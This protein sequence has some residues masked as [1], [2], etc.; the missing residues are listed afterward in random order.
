MTCQT[1]GR[2]PISISGLGRS[3]L[4]RV[5]RPPQRIETHLHRRP[6]GADA[7][8]S[9]RSPTRRPR[10]RSPRACRC[11]AR[12]VLDLGCAAGGLATLL[13]ARG[14]VEVVGIERRRRTTRRRRR[15]RCD[16]V[17]RPTPRRSPT[18]RP[19][20]RARPL[21]LP[22]RR[23]RARAPRRPV[24]A[25]CAR[26]A[27]LLE[28]GGTA[29]VSLPNVGHWSTYAAPRPRQLAAQARGHPRRHAPAL[30][31][32]AR[33][34]RA[35]ASRPGLQAAAV[36]RRR[37]CCWRGSRLDALAPPPLRVPGVRTLV[38]VP[39]RARRAYPARRMP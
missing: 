30:V 4:R 7:C 32:A 20:G 25:R 29:V 17:V 18:R 14:E 19:R 36:E 9:A 31:H 22:R 35:A 6:Y 21:R 39:A 27:R 2:P 26:Y 3:P 10:P 1:I 24:D 23:R 15:A 28:P 11:G 8:R 38:H 37:G 16:R 13:K 33:R 5:P 34:A 12:R